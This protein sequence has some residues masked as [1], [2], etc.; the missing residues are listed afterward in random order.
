MDAAGLAA[1]GTA[2]LLTTA[3]ATR[4]RGFNLGGNNGGNNGGNGLFFFF[5]KTNF[6]ENGCE[7][8]HGNLFPLYKLG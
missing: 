4:L 6:F 2:G 8:A 5:T 1:T 7:D 3:G